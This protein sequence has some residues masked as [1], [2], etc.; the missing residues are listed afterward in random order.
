MR[1]WPN[2][3][4]LALKR[5]SKIKASPSL[6]PALGGVQGNGGRGGEGFM[7]YCSLL[8]GD[9]LATA[10]RR[11]SGGSQA[12]PS[13]VVKTTSRTENHAHLSLERSSTADSCERNLT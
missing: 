3:P 6:S 7:L 2:D 5:R 4:R 1:F 11:T 10:S 13:R 8:L 9:S 12:P